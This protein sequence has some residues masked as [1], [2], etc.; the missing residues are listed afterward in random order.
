VKDMG[1]G[2]LLAESLTA[3]LWCTSL[4]TLHDLT[5]EVNYPESSCSTRM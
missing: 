3:Y 2:N 1:Y 4:P 5:Y